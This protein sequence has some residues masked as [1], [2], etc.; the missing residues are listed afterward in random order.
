VPTISQNGTI[1]TSS[2]PANNQWYLNGSPIPGATGTTYDM[3]LT[4]SGSYTVRV[5]IDGC[6]ST[7][8]PVIYTSLDDELA[9]A[10][11]S[12]YPNPVSDLLTISF[13]RPLPANATLSIYNTLGELVHTEVLTGSTRHIH[14]PYPAGAYSVEINSGESKWI[15]QVVK[16]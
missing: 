12:I 11:I 2:A 4:G 8:L 3:A 16:L 10:G 13:E 5:T 14:W 6:S 15:A 1:L 7:S 9:A